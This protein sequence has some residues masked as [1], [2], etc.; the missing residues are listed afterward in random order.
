MSATTG[1]PDELL[2]FAPTADA[3][4]VRDSP[5]AN[6]GSSVKLEVD[7]SPVQAA[8]LK[9][10]VSGIGSRKITDAKLRLYNVNSSDSGGNVHRAASNAWTEGGVTWD[11]APAADPIVLASLPAVTTG[12]WYQAGVASAVTGDGDV[13]FRIQT[14][15]SD[16]A[17]YSSKEGTSGF[18][19]QLVIAVAAGE[20]DT[21]PPTAPSNLSATATSSSRVDLAWTASTDDR[22]V[23]HYGIVRNSVQ[24][25]TTT[26][27]TYADTSVAAATSYS[28]YVVAYDAAGNVSPPSNVV[29]VTTPQQSTSETLVFAVTT[30][31]TIRDD[32]PTTNFGAATTVATDASPVKDSLFKLAVSG[33]GTRTVVSAM[34]RLAC[35]DASNRGGD[36]FKAASNDWSESTVTWNTAPSIVGS[37]LASLGG[38]S[39]GQT[40]D[41]DVTPLV[42][43]DG[44]YSVRMNSTSTNGADYASSEATTGRPQ[45]IV[46]VR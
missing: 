33:V 7:N 6:Y 14:M 43:G 10:S 30:D 29:S 17:D 34:L 44:T 5:S 31:A 24:I 23:K 19:P 21:S 1:P 9:F 12:N 41:V 40:V 36:F 26:S 25:A 18:A 3:T 13:S 37:A 42:T 16:G 8:L 46:T 35:V 15:S 32:K 38:V 22:G 45:L 20:P 27:T 2:I 4:V 11:T 39:A 28:Y